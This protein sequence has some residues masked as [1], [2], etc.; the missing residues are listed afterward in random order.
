MRLETA[1]FRGMVV[2]DKKWRVSLHV[3][4]FFVFAK[5]KIKVE[6]KPFQRSYI[7]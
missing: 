5:K 4:I 3:E 7:Q 2:V 6:K 1:I